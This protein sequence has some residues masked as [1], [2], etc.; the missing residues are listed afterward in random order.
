MTNANPLSS[1]DFPPAS[2]V[3]VGACPCGQVHVRFGDAALRLS[4]DQA[5]SLVAALTRATTVARD[6]RAARLH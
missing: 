4:P 6:A 1:N 5:E 2:P 3:S